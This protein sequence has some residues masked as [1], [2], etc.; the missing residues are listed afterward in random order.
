MTNHL[1]ME[2]GE[3]IGR[4]KELGIHK[5][6]RKVHISSGKA[7]M[8]RSRGPNERARKYQQ[9]PISNSLFLKVLVSE[10]SPPVWE[11]LP[12]GG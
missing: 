11:N 10:V 6:G 1:G 12:K 4:D 7:M 8:I 3:F 9:H 2:G 5:R